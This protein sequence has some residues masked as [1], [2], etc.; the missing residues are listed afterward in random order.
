MRKLIR[1]IV[2]VGI[3]TAIILWL[4]DNNL[5]PKRFYKAGDFDIIVIKSTTDYDNDKIDDYTDILQGAKKE[6][7]KHPSY[8]SVYYSG[9]YPPVNEGVCTDVI[10]RS[11]KNAGYDLKKLV[12]NDIKNHP[13][14]YS[15]IDKPDPNIDF[16]R[17]KNLLAYFSHTAIILTNSLDQIEEWMPGDIVVFG[18]KHIAII[19]DRRNK[20]GLPYIIHN[21]GQ[22]NRDEDAII[23]WNN[24]YSIIGHYRLMTK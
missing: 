24:R 23:K 7:E 16:R 4:Y 13:K 1:L 6:A 20:E 22:P 21:S 18:T 15:N 9:G 19:S 3:I 5:I 12:D 11:L 17:V 8:K 10:W 14:L 2:F